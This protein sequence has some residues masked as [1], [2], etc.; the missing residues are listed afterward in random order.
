MQKPGIAE[1]FKF[2][3]SDN[4]HV[5]HKRRRIGVV[6]PDLTILRRIQF[7]VCQIQGSSREMPR[8]AF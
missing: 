7:D 5:G 4:Q 3:H 6:R 2:S 1:D 8:L